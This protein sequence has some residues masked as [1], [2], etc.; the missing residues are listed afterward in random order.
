MILNT[1]LKGGYNYSGCFGGGFTW[2]SVYLAY[3]K[4][5]CK[6]KKTNKYGFKRNSEPNQIC[7]K[8]R[9]CRVKLEMDALKSPLELL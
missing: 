6:L 9:C 8:F 1:Y 2:G 4:N 7:S 3:D 5:N